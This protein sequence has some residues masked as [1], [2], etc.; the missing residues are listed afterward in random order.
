MQI[1]LN[2]EEL[3]LIKT[4]DTKK[5][6]WGNDPKLKDNP[7]FKALAQYNEKEIIYG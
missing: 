5:M 7:K 2:D 3:E 6:G 4:I 1:L